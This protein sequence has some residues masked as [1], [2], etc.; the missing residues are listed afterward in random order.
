MFSFSFSC[1][2]FFFFLPALIFFYHSTPLSQLFPEER[3]CLRWSSRLLPLRNNTV[4]IWQVCLFIKKI[5]SCVENEFAVSSRFRIRWRNLSQSAVGHWTGDSDQSFFFN[6]PTLKIYKEA[7]SQSDNIFKGVW[8]A[9][10]RVWKLINKM[11]KEMKLLSDPSRPFYI[12][13]LNIT[14]GTNLCR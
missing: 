4:F 2:C 10:Q 13:Q 7:S 14:V 12:H 11:A 3:C 6:S 5:F 1:S 8:T 9:V